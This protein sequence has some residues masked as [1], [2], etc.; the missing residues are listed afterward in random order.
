MAAGKEVPFSPVFPPH[1]IYPHLL[2]SVINCALY[3]EWLGEI[4]LPVFVVS[5][6]ATG[7]DTS[8]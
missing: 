7:L 8:T 2:F 1:S 4:I 3:G 5:G 6:S